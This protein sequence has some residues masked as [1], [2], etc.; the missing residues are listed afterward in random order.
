MVSYQEE[1]SLVEINW[2]PVDLNSSET[3]S[4]EHRDNQTV[5]SEK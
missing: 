1:E 5:I 2:S 3:V 4:K